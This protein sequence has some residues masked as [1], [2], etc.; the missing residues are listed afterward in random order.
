MKPVSEL[1]AVNQPIRKK[2]YKALVTGQPVYTQDL[3][4]ADCLVV[5]L[6]RSPHASPGGG[7]RCLPG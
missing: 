7:Y 1:R 2:D 3:A 6:L 4:P 5:K